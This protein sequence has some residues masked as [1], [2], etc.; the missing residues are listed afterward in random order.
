M[1]RKKPTFRKRNERIQVY[2]SSINEND[3]LVL[4][5]WDAASKNERV[6]E[7]FRAILRNGIR[8]MVENGDMPSS[9]VKELDLLHLFPAR[10]SAPAM[11]MMPY[12]PP[13]APYG[14]PPEQP[15]RHERSGFG[16]GYEPDFREPAMREAIPPREPAAEPMPEPPPRDVPP[17]L[18]EITAPA[19]KAAKAGKDNTSDS[20]GPSIGDML[21]L[22]GNRRS[23][24]GR[25]G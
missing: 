18:V 6:Q 4:D 15:G 13:P 25:Q 14:Y 16:N 20:Q 8:T 5:I 22:M 11:P 24:D 1:P 21:G 17:R 19:P 23:S 10:A 2:L 9:I 7:V 12:Y 3:A